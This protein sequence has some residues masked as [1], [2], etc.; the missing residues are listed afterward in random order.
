MFERTARVALCLALT[1]G[2]AFCARAA[3][4][5][6]K[7]IV[8]APITP[9][10]Q[11]HAAVR[12]GRL[13][14][15]AHL[16]GDGVPV[17]A[18]DALGSTPLIDAAWSGNAE[19]CQFLLQHGAD[20]NA[21]H[22]EAHSTALEYAVLTGRVAIVKLLLSAGARVD[23][24][25]R[26]RQTVLHLAAERG[27][28]QIVE[29]LLAAHAD[30]GAVDSEDNTPL[31]EALL[32]GQVQAVRTLIAHGADAKRVHA[33]D[34]RGT[35]HEVAIKGFAPMVQ[36]IVD[37]GA[38]PAARDRS[39]QTPLDLALA[40]KNANVVTALLKAGLNLKESEAAAEEAMETA[41]MRGQTEIAR[42]LIESGF[43][44]TKPTGAGSTYLHDAALKGKKKV[45]E[46][47][48]E[49]GAHVNALNRNGGTPLHDAALGGSPEVITVLLD[50][51][52]V[53]D[54]RDG[55][56]DATPLMLAASMGR[57]KAVALLLAR[58]AN[59]ALRDRSGHTAL[60]RA[61][62]TDDE[63]T[64]SLLK[65]ALAESSAASKSKG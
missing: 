7:P 56:A 35:L 3:Q 11:L 14:E 37:A 9:A 30:V 55:D 62:E 57:G 21:V 29:L 33:S 54:A 61:Q 43:D 49:H 31:D 17:D 58:G 32:H 5:G 28:S 1:V 48:I 42:V 27:N 51:G 19:T 45:V 18:R 47:L 52:A 50:H 8:A 20:V 60:D 16:I 63:T 38:D 64:Q 6:A 26:D 25:Y 4:D 46:L 36:P 59:P 65:N 40:Y 34:N 2:A 12:N 53:I 13:A 10:E 22:Q 39:G 41:T 23:K 24:E 15:V 44:I